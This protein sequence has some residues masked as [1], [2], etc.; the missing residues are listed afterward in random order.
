M[1]DNDIEL[2]D[3]VKDAITGCK[4]I[5]IGIT[6]WINGCTRLV[7]QPVI[8]C[9]PKPIETFELDVEQAIKTN[10][11]PKKKSSKSGGPTPAVK[12]SSVLDNR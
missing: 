4:G 5:V 12:R 7:V 9:D 8:K 6:D 10:K 11:K 2:G 3:E 1:R